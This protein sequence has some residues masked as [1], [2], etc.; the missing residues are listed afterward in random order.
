M[1]YFNEFPVIDYNLSGENGNT[2]KVTDIFRRVKIRDKISN[3]VTLF[4]RYDVQEGEKPEELCADARRD[5][6]LGS[7]T[8]PKL[9]ERLQ[10]F[11]F[12][13][14]RPSWNSAT[15][16]VVQPKNSSRAWHLR[17][18]GRRGSVENGRPSRRVSF[19]KRPCHTY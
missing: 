4:D 16:N 19:R 10:H 2:K 18:P 17:V 8:P 6:T 9:P 12:G 5:A 15:G 7:T 3:N 14:Q 13:I 11:C 1:R